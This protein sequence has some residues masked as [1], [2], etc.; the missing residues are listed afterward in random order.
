MSWCLCTQLSF[1]NGEL[2]FNFPTSSMSMLTSP[3]GTVSVSA[4]HNLLDDSNFHDLSLE[5]E[6]ERTFYHEKSKDLQ[7]QL[8][9]LKSEIEELK[10]GAKI[11]ILVTTAL[12]MI[13]L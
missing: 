3:V 12:N 10:V 5:I 8:R 2:S 9:T 7:E 1:S 6:K 4:S 13:C 11:M